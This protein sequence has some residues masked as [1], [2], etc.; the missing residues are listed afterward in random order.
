MVV[1]TCL[2]VDKR[3][4]A[5]DFACSE[6][7]QVLI[8]RLQLNE[9]CIL[10]HQIQ[11]FRVNTICTRL[12]SPR[13]LTLML[14]RRLKLAGSKCDFNQKRLFAFNLFALALEPCRNEAR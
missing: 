9:T 11:A 10:S 3:S 8:R 7:Y 13:N 1:Y 5:E 4:V 12:C 14:G 2:E 6:Q